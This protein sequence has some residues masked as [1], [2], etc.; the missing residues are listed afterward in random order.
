MA[1]LSE[2]WRCNDNEAYFAAMNINGIISQVEK[3][4]K[5]KQLDGSSFEY[6]K[7]GQLFVSAGKGYW[8]YLKR[9]PRRTKKPSRDYWKNFLFGSRYKTEEEQTRDHEIWFEECLKYG[10]GSSMVAYAH[11]SNTCLWTENFPLPRRFKTLEGT[12]KDSRRMSKKHYIAGIVFWH[13]LHEKYS[14][15]H[16]LTPERAII[17]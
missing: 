16:G 9:R 15:R 4:R 8:S 3:L 6:V 5:G 17:R 12:L 14:R 13:K 11:I 1:V 7:M 2:W 10:L